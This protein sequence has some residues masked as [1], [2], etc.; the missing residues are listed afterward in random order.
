MPLDEDKISEVS[1]NILSLIKQF[2]YFGYRS[3]FDYFFYK[4][5]M[6]YRKD[7]SISLSSLLEK[8]KNNLYLCF[9][10]GTL[11]YW[12]MAQQKAEIKPFPDFEKQ[13]QN[14][15]SNLISLEDFKL[16]DLNNDD[17]DFVSNK[18]GIIYE[19]LDLMKSKARLVSTSKTLH[20]LLPYLVIP[21]DNKYT[22]S[23]F[24]VSENYKIYKGKKCKDPT[25][26]LKIFEYS[27]KIA[28]KIKNIVRKNELL[29]DEWNQTIPKIIDN[30][31][32]QYAS[33]KDR[34]KTLRNK[35]EKP[36]FHIPENLINEI[37]NKVK[38]II[39]V[40][41]QRIEQ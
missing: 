4:I 17:F 1:E 31:I 35:L 29:N 23:Y 19:G 3:D 2:E 30:A 20:F 37:I 34:F 9:L 12:D 5:I 21:M 7:P 33:N 40:K 38:D 25:P 18:L 36:K 16:E 6:K 22:K 11:I 10:Y 8:K 14:Q 28:K 32:I 15:F 24:S 13:I 41:N 26:F 27:W 39:K